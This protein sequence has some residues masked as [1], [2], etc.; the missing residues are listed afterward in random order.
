[1]PAERGDIISRLHREGTVLSSEVDGESMVITARLPAERRS[2]FSPYM[3]G[4]G[5]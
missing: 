1:V 2:A 3:A 5:R 4:D